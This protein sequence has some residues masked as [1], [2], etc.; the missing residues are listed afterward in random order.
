MCSS[1]LFFFFKQKTAYEM[2]IS[3]W[4]SD[5]CSSD[6]FRNGALLGS[7]ETLSLEQ[8]QTLIDTAL[9][10]C[11]R[12]YPVFQLVLWGGKT[13][14]EAISASLIENRG[15]ACSRVMRANRFPEHLFLVGCGNMP[16]PM[17]ARWIEC[18]RHP[19]SVTV[20]RISGKL[21]KKQRAG[22]D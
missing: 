20:S 8:A 19:S 3:D 10:E 9:D 13:P 18:G 4:S 5:V 2:R 22:K 7:G 16:G 6:L 17:L 15:Q 21:V 12:F 11:A 14:Q 1:S